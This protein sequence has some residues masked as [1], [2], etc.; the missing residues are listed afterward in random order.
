MHLSIDQP[1]HT[2]RTRL[3]GIGAA[4]L[5]DLF[6]YR[7]LPAV[8]RYIPGEPLTHE[9]VQDAIATRWARRSIDNEGEG[10]LIGI[11][12][13]S[14]EH[15]IGDVSLWV[16]SM[17]D[18]CGEIGW[19]LNP[20]FTGQGFAAETTHGVLHLAFSELGLRRVIARVMRAT[21]HH[22]GLLQDSAC[23][24]RPTW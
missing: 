10:V 13:V 23:A 9:Q 14:S 16:R 5:D 17:H 20:T 18:S 12:L 19:I 8:F 3:R 4:D 15:L 2:A 21:L 6:A 11:E 22:F 7:S 24:K 1:R